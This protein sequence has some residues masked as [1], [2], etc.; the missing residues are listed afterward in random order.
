MIKDQHNKGVRMKDDKLSHGYATSKDYQRLWELVKSFRIVCFVN[1]GEKREDGYQLRDVCQ[2]SVRYREGDVGIG[3]RG[4]AYIS[5]FSKEE[6]L[7]QCAESDLEYIDVGQEVPEAK[8]SK[9]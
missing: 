3:S 8:N 6:F 2:S 1:A 4:M 5:A 9:D 7:E